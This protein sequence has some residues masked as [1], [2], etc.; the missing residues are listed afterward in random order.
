MNAR[1]ELPIQPDTLTTQRNYVGQSVPRAGA[2]KL[3]EGRGTYL[4]EYAFPVW[5]MWCTLEV[6]MHMPVSSI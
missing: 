4:D 1:N 5:C 6:P 3:L 2:K